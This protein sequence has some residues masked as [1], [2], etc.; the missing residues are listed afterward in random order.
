MEIFWSPS[1]LTAEV[2]VS[3]AHHTELGVWLQLI[4]MAMGQTGRSVQR[5]GVACTALYIYIPWIYQF[6]GLFTVKITPVS[7]CKLTLLGL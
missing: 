1:R 4:S 2:E 6:K 3:R 7:R 5:R